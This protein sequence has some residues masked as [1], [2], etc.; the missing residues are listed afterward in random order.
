MMAGGVFQALPASSLV[1]ADWL[2]ALSWVR[3]IHPAF[4]Y[5]VALQM[6]IGRQVVELMMGQYTHTDFVRATTG[7]ACML[8]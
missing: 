8:A 1:C 5:C 7:Q 2:A 4:A 6:S 3:R